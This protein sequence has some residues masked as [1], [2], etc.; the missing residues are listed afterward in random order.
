MAK[1]QQVGN[2]LIITN[3]QN[4]DSGRYRCRCITDEG[5]V[6]TSV[7][8]LTIDNLPSHSE[9][10]PPKVEHAEVGSNVVLRC[11]AD[12]YPAIFQWTRQHGQFAAGQNLES[13][14]HCQ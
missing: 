6:Y 9:I 13:V 11:N 14:S 2:Q 8:E 5:E 3:V 12:R 1:L 10:R 7:Y 4:Q